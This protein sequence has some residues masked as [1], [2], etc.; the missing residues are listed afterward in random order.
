M[1]QG[2]SPWPAPIHKRPSNISRRSG[3]VVKRQGVSSI[4]VF[5]IVCSI[6]D[7]FFGV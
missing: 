1:G 5:L 3:T 7:V 2:I 4:G 6:I